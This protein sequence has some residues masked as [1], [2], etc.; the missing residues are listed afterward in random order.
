MEWEIAYG[1]NQKRSVLYWPDAADWSAPEKIRGG[2]PI[3]FPFV[4]R[5]FADGQENHWDCPGHGILP[6]PRHGFARQG[7]FEIEQQEPTGFTARLVPQ[8]VDQQCYP[9]K[10]AFRVQYLFEP[11]GFRVC[12]SLSNLDQVII[13][14]CAGHHFYFQLPWHQGL[15]R[16]DY[17]FEHTAK[18]TYHQ[19]LAGELI[20]GQKTS[21]CLA[22]DD[23]NLLDCM[24]THLKFPEVRFGPKGG[25]EPV[26][27]AIRPSPAVSMW[28]TFTTWTL[29]ADSPFYCVEPWMGPANAPG[30]KKGLHY[31]NPGETQTFMVDVYVG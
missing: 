21:L 27:I 31:V 4:A 16:R 30:L 5:T 11:L 23:P 10:Y 1:H 17:A 15:T 26:C 9:F 28:S 6:M 3:L 7:L 12:L 8:S 20:K 24:H 13:P 18:K 2:N 14:W 25:E 29:D 19:G 22:M